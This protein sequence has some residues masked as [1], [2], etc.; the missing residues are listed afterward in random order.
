M[1]LEFFQRHRAG[2]LMLGF[3]AFS[4]LCMALR[5][6]ATVNALK[7]SAW[8]LVSPAVVESGDFFNTLDSSAARFFGLIR[9]EAE[10][11]ILREQNAQL[12]KREV[13]RDALEEE[14]N[15][16]RTL[17]NFKLHSFPQGIPAE[18]V[19][20]DMRDWF[21]AISINKGAAD[22]VTLSAAVVSGTTEKPTLVGRIAEV[23]EGSSKVLLLTDSLSA[24]SVTDTRTGDMG[25]LEGQNKPTA[26]L[27]YL[28]HL[29]S[30][31]VDDVVVTA[32]LGGIFPPGVPVGRVISVKDS[33]DGFFKEA[34]VEPF[35]NFGSLRELLVLERRELT[36]EKVRP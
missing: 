25:L 30:V 36:G 24:I 18:L 16:L 8:F 33:S 22:G 19:G 32:G 17:L 3:A 20:R 14:N 1:L 4:F 29:S 11:T 15:R 31:L 12:S 10:N 7:A 2:V 5:V 23:R 6:A 26:K 28:P 21:R 35:A 34:V 13:E 9:A 27:N